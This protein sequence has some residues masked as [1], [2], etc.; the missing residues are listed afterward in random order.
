[1]N[2]KNRDEIATNMRIRRSVEKFLRLKRLKFCINCENI[3]ARENFL[4]RQEANRESRRSVDD[5]RDRLEA[6]NG[7]GD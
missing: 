1:M 6:R 4:Y 3:D 2:S 7:A 5:F